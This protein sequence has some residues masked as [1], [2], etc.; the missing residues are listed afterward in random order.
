MRK[1]VSI[2]LA[3][4]MTVTCAACSMQPKESKKLILSEGVEDRFYTESAVDSWYT[5][6]ESDTICVT[7]ERMVLD[8]RVLTQLPVSVEKN[9]TLSFSVELQNSGE[10]CVM[11]KYVQDGESQASEVLCDVTDGKGQTRVAQLQ[12]PWSDTIRKATDRSGNEIA[13]KQSVLDRTIAS[14]FLEYSAISKKEMGWE[15]EA[16]EK[17]TLSLT[18]R[19]QNI[20]IEEILL[21][22]KK[23]ASDYVAGRKPGDVPTIIVEAEEYALKSD[24]YIKA[25]AVKNTALF[26]YDTYHKKINTIDGGTWSTPGQKILWEVNVEKE[27]DYR[28]GLR[29][30]QNADANKTVFRRIEI[31][32]KVPFSQWEHAAIPYTGS[33][34]YHNVTLQADGEDAVFHLSKGMHT[35]AMTVS[36]GV[37]ENVYNDIFLLMKDVNTLGTELMKLTGGITDENRTWNM[38]E[39]MPDATKRIKEYAKR[40]EEIYQQLGEK[41]GKDAVYAMDLLTASEKL[42]NLLKE[43]ERI[44]GKTEDISRGDDSASKYLGNVLSV[45]TSQ[46]VTVD[47]LYVYGQKKLP[48]AKSGFLTSIVDSVKRF[49]WSFLPEASEGSISADENKDE[50][51]VWVGQTAM[52]VDVLQ[53]MVDETYN[54]EHGTNIRLVVM[55]N[56]QK[57]VL[58][59]A[60][61]TNPDVVLC[62]SSGLPFTFASRGA[63]KNFLEYDEFREKYG[64]QYRVDSLVPVCYGDGVYGAVDSQNF[65]LLFYRKDI[66]ASLGLD[67]P[68]TWSDVRAMMPVLLRNQM[69]FYIPVSVGNALKGLGLTSPYIYQH[70]GELYTEDGSATAIDCENAIDAMSELT[71]FYR[72]YAMQQTVQNFYLSFRYG[73]VPIGI[74][75]F[76]TYLQLKMAAPELTGLWGVALCPGNK[77]EDGTV[78]RYQPATATASMVFANTDKEKE[79]W[80]FLSWWLS[81]ETQYEF[82]SRRISVYGPEYQWNT[83]NLS[84]FARIPFDSEVKG[85]VMEQW[86]N[87]REITP[88]PASYIVERE[89]SGVWNDVVVDNSSLIES[90]DQAVLVSNREIARKLME[91]GYMDEE[92]NLIR[93]YDIKVLEMLDKEFGESR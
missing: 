7:P 78:L 68:E 12:L 42:Q 77:Q 15:I 1:K 60:T 19:E 55:P 82:S 48:S 37:Y 69:N 36:M 92:G 58:A 18:P 91:F 90:L 47:R 3:V 5:A 14:P 89:L 24:S 75:D 76:N 33:S 43:P 79:A 85:L 9:N 64:S 88:H 32:G 51:K 56:E 35:I 70:K 23:E 6:G 13:P 61:G 83:A 49:A 63:L 2:L 62:A 25:S 74:G 8:G 44:P 40:A 20:C 84:A 4:I 30:K 54:K 38:E 65:Q 59:N 39:Y 29:C 87:Q 46:G 57:L 72:I 81:E 34:D 45:L 71:D 80:E 86:K 66:L 73:E 10:Y 50:L 17:W 31:D 52:M 22:Q 67:V 27:G 11:L 16:G 53:Q 93:D 41:D 26:P 28:L 21:Y